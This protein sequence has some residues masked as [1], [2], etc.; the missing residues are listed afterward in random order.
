MIYVLSRTKPNWGI[1]SRHGSLCRQ[2]QKADLVYDLGC[3]DG[4]IVI[5][6][7]K[8]YRAHGGSIDINPQRI[9]D[10]KENAKKAG[11]ETLVLICCG[12]SVRFRMLCLRKD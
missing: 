12:F 2:R 3:D 4:R 11:V 7:A 5:A 8:E 10:A 1:G 9:Q 6:A